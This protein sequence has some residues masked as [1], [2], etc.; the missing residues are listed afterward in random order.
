MSIITKEGF[1]SQFRIFSKDM[2]GQTAYKATELLVQEVGGERRYKNY[3]S[4]KASISKSHRSG[5]VV[6][7][8]M[9]QTKTQS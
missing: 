9:K 7:K 8:R 4:F 5:I 6:I 2:R 1:I 3:S